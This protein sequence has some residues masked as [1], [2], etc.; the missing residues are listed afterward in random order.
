MNEE[1][2]KRYYWMTS[3]DMNGQLMKIMTILVMW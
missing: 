3:E 2:M 1:V